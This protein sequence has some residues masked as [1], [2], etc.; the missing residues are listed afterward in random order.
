MHTN[1]SDVDTM[2]NYESVM[3]AIKRLEKAHMKHIEIY[4]AEN[5]ARMTGEHETSHISEFSHGVANRGCSVRIPRETFGN[6]KGYLEDRRPAS[7]IDP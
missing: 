1:Y 3:N 7:N 5:G 2:N 6:K 4:G